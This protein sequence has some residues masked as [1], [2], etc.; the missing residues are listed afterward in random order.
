MSDSDA[1][2]VRACGGVINLYSA[3]PQMSNGNRRE[4]RVSVEGCWVWLWST[5]GWVVAC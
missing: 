3:F 5:G 4:D 1:G 2:V